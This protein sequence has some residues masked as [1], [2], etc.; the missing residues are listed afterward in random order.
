MRALSAYVRLGSTQP[1][2]P[3]AA[4]NPALLLPP[5]LLTQPLISP[6][7]HLFID[8]F[9]HQSLLL[10]DSIPQLNLSPTYSPKPGSSFTLALTLTRVL[11]SGADLGKE[12][13]LKWPTRH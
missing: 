6:V 12:L 4:S 3:Q 7:Q 10:P 13:E 1:R 5:R 11:T 9:Y 8:P 2:T